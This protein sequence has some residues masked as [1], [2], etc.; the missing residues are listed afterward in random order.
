MAPVRF[1]I[2]NLASVLPPGGLTFVQ[3]C[4]G[5]SA[6]LAKAVATA[7]DALGAMTFTGVFVPGLNRTPY[8]AN[9][10]CRVR[11]FFMTPELR[12][13][14]DSVDFLPFCYADILTHLRMERID[15]ALFTVSP[16]IKTAIAASGRSSTFLPSCGRRF[17]CGSRIS[18]RL[19]PART[20]TQASLSPN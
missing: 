8:I 16:P 19:C 17:P 2:S 13:A 11:T 5:E 15:A 1:D 20:A 9:P 3:G 7:G 12:A 4:S 14:G 18:T 10:A 6:L